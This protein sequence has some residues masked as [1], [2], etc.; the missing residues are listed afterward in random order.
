LFSSACFRISAI[1]GV[2]TRD[3]FVSWLRTLRTT[4]G[5]ERTVREVFVD[6]KSKTAF[7]QQVC[8]CDSQ[9]AL[10]VNVVQWDL[11]FK[12]IINIR[13]YGAGFGAK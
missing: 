2:K 8:T 9:S 6:H 5:F 11:D 3:S 13:E 4:S 12:C 10:V 1:D 7:L